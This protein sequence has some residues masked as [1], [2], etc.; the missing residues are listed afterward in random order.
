MTLSWTLSRTLTCIRQNRLFG[1]IQ[2]GL[3]LLAVGCSEDANVTPLPAGASGTSGANA[4]GSASGGSNTGASAGVGN[5]GQSGSGGES[6]NSGQSGQSGSSGSSATGGG[7]SGGSQGGN[8]GTAGH[9][10]V[11]GGGNSGAGQAGASGSSPQCGNNVVELGEQCD[12]SATTGVDCESLGLGSGTPTC[13]DD[14]T[15]DLSN[16]SVAAQC[17]NFQCEAGENV[18]NCPQDCSTCFNGICE[19]WEDQ[20]NCPADCTPNNCPH[21]FCFEGEPLA[22]ECGPCEQAICNTMPECCTNGWDINCVNAVG[23]ICQVQCCGDGACNQATESCSSCPQDCGGCP[24]PATCVHSAC[25][26][27]VALEATQC[28]DACTEQVCAANSQCCQGQNW[29]SECQTLSEQICSTSCVANVCAMDA[30]CCTTDW[31]SACVDLAKTQCT[32]GCNCAHDI[33]VMGDPL[34]PTCDPCVAEICKV[35]SYC[36]DNG[37]DQVCLGEVGTICRIECP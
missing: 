16:C 1:L 20:N 13:K 6:G 12:G 5:S 30:S 29:A 33:C 26:Q 27:G 14:C 22:V 19:P 34:S 4:G 8:A 25:T 36:C 15:F 35:D 11:A 31:T 23:T 32:T 10:G 37:F 2:G 17:G 21:E 3:L 28:P 7:G 18:D 24:L 9:A